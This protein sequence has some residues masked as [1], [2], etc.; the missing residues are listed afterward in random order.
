LTDF[1]CWAKIFPGQMRTM[2]PNNNTVALTFLF[3][4][5]SFAVN[6]DFVFGAGCSS[7]DPKSFGLYGSL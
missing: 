3:I 2:I 6:P 1:F 7:I 4:I 5:V